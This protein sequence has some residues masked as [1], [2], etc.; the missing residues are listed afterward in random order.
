M[1]TK[2]AGTP[3]IGRIDLI[4]IYLTLSALFL[5]IPNS[6]SA[7]L[8]IGVV[9]ISQRQIPMIITKPGSYRLVG[10]LN[11]SSP[12]VTA[13]SI[14]T[15]NVTIDL[16]GFTISGPG[17]QVGDIPAFGIVNAVTRTVNNVAVRNGTVQGFG[18]G[19]HLPGNQNRV[20]N[21]HIYNTAHG[22]FVGRASI[23]SQCLVAYCYSEGINTD[24]GTL[25]LSNTIYSINGHGIMTSGDAPGPVGGVTLMG[26]NIRLC[27]TG[28]RAKGQGNR[29]EGNTITQCSTGIDLSEGSANY[30]AKNLLQG[31]GSPWTGDYDEINGNSIDSALSNIIIPM[32]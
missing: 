31:N 13:I 24:D 26:N 1:R 12:N 32:P 21:I 9:S 30:F 11:V 15:D 8:G 18:L 23:V 20:E 5:C 4:I 14:D 2:K 29:I 10:N 27:G 28:I 19:V 16:N 7:D 6:F 3:F 25:V 22:I 17:F